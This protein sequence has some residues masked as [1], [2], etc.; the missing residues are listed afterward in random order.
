MSLTDIICHSYST[1]KMQHCLLLFNTEKNVTNNYSVWIWVVVCAIKYLPSSDLHE[2]TH[3]VLVLWYPGSWQCNPNPIAVAHNKFQLLA[4]NAL[5][6][7]SSSANCY[8]FIPY[9]GMARSADWCLGSLHKHFAFF[10][11]KNVSQSARD[12]N[13]VVHGESDNSLNRLPLAK[14][15][16]PATKLKG[17]PFF[18]GYN[19]YHEHGTLQTAGYYHYSTCEHYFPS[20]SVS[21][22]TFQKCLLCTRH[23]KKCV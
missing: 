10:F 1:T 9:F 8:W 4:G 7:R 16:H 15:L 3:A 13:R 19:K 12:D 20:L 23:S 17:M 2:K 22:L 6:H 18:G 21:F 14:A 5:G 11:T